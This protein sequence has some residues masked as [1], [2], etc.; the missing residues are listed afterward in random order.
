M[1][2]LLKLEFGINLDNFILDVHFQV[3]ISWGYVYILIAGGNR[4]RNQY[5]HGKRQKR[6]YFIYI[7]V[8]YSLSLVIV[9]F[10]F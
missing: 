7:V 1:W 5:S 3:L 9:F 10:N 8:E 4:I 6:F 2:L